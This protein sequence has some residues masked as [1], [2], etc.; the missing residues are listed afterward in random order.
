METYSDGTFGRD[1]IIAACHYLLQHGHTS[2]G[3]SLLSPQNCS[4]AAEAPRPALE[5]FPASSQSRR[6]CPQ[7]PDR[8]RQKES[9]YVARTHA[10]TYRFA[11]RS[12]CRP[13][14]SSSRVLTRIVSTEYHL[15][16]SRSTMTPP[17]A[18]RLPRQTQAHKIHVTSPRGSTRVT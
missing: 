2:L 10:R 13:S 1:L 8:R 11:K 4:A 14:E 7:N 15:P 3:A 12:V 9:P 17:Q 5:R 6:H 16:G 18:P